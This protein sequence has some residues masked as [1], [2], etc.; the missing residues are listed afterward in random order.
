VIA[1]QPVDNVSVLAVALYGAI[2][3]GLDQAGPQPYQ[4]MFGHYE[5]QAKR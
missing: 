5:Q 1:D 2:L 3:R 4:A